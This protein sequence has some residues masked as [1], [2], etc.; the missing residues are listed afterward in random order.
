MINKESTFS[1]LYSIR[2]FLVSNLRTREDYTRA[3]YIRCC[4]FLIKIKFHGINIFTHR[5][6]TDNITTKKR[7]TR[8]KNQYLIY[9][10][11]QSLTS[12]MYCRRKVCVSPTRTNQY[13]IEMSV[14]EINKEKNSK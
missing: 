4:Y 14:G 1:V 10:V 8:K 7:K 11:T 9:Y 2:D 12:I 3:T 6:I 13:G 5:L